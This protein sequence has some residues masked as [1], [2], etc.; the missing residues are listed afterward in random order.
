MNLF[1]LDRSPRIAAQFLCDAHVVKMILE[2]A[3]LLSTQDRLN[4]LERGYRMTHEN[5]PCRRCLENPANYLWLSAHLGSLL[6]EYTHRFRK[7]HRTEQLFRLYWK[8]DFRCMS[9]GAFAEKLSLPKCMPA[10]YRV[11]GDGIDDVVA[12][13]R[14]YYQFKR[15]TLP[16]FRYTRRP[17][18]AWLHEPFLP[19]KT[20]IPGGTGDF[21][22]G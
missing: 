17:P 7:E 1:V 15:L 12:S 16:R 8:R 11:G 18:P 20:E 4:G 2:S 10:E 6:R 22:M 21:K 5:H 13:Y 9:G 19:E 3:Q 14:N